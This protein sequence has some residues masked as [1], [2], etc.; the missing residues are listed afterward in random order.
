MQLLQAKA[1]VSLVPIANFGAVEMIHYLRES[2]FIWMRCL[3]SFAEPNIG[4]SPYFIEVVIDP[5]S[6]LLLQD[7]HL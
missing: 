7:P 3:N 5:Q 6:P 2:T 4:P 1:Y